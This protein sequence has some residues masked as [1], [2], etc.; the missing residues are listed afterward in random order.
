MPKLAPLFLLVAAALSSGCAATLIPNT[1]VEDTTENR[2]VV[3]F[4]ESYRHAVQARDVRKL[5]SLASPD[6]LDHNGTVSGSDDVDLETL[7]AKITALQS[8]IEDVRFEIRYR[9]VTFRG[10]RVFID[11]T[12]TGSFRIGE[13]GGGHHWSRRLSDQRIVL[14]KKND[15]FLILS[16]M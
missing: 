8:A 12:Y 1:D 14:E 4:V 7:R 3:A 9:R 16:G 5:L 13:P 15:S 11:L 10:E 2:D 6:Y